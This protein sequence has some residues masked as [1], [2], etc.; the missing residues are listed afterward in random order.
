MNNNILHPITN[1]VDTRSK[2]LIDMDKRAVLKFAKS[3]RCPSSCF[4]HG[5]HR[6]GYIENTELTNYYR[7]TNQLPENEEI[8]DLCCL[9]CGKKFKERICFIIDSSE[10][11]KDDLK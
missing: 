11:N 5:K 6:A 1:C 7:Q 2:E 8:R 4:A 3:G 10:V 9:E